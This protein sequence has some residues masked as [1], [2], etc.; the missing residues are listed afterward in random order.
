MVALVPSQTCR[1][2]RPLFG[3][4]KTRVTGRPGSACQGHLSKLTLYS[5]AEPARRESTGFV[6]QTASRGAT[7][8]GIL[9][10]GS[11][12][13]IRWFSVTYHNPDTQCF[14]CISP[15]ALLN[16]AKVVSRRQE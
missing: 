4:S 16:A 14:F 9:R 11:I 2:L 3:P 7:R 13:K 12:T 8:L 15:V 1:V 6:V 10:P 5:E